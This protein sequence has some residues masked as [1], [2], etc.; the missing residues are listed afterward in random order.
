V[1]N[2]KRAF[3]VDA[4]RERKPVHDERVTHGVIGVIGAGSM[5]AESMALVA[6]HTGQDCVY[7]VWVVR[8]DG[9]AVDRCVLLALKRL[10]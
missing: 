4:Y 7:S 5:G 6:L 8:F 2:E 10:Y 9:W 3:I 1:S